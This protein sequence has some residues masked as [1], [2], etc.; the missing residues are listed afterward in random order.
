MKKKK[1]CSKNGREGGDQE[2]CQN[3]EKERKDKKAI[4]SGN[5]KTYV[6]RI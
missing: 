3:R 4:G 2:R 5:A 1:A 6:V